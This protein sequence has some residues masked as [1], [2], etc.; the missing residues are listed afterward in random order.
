MA[1]FLTHLF[2]PLTAAFV[3]SRETFDS[4]VYLLLGG[5]GLLADFDKFL[6][7][8]GL[9]HSLITL[10]IIVGLGVAIERLWRG[11][12]V[13]APLAGGLV[14]SHL[15][16]DLVD[17]GPVPLLYPLTDVGV[18]LRYPA[19]VAFGVD[20][21]GIE[22]RGA[23]VEVITSAPRGGFNEYGF[24]DGVGVANMLLFLVV[25]GGLRRTS[26]SSEGRH[27]EVADARQTDSKR[28]W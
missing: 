5:F 4:P 19:R 6:G 2:L 23:L 7:V 10:G 16:L 24:I 12:Y 3:L 25:Y 8:P 20:P 28:R 27:R 1:D 21:L 22:L 26:T 13:L 9:L 11:E 14:L 15:V 18:G 17:G